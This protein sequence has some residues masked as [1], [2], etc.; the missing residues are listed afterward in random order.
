MKNAVFWDV[1][2][3][4]LVL[5]RH[6]LKQNTPLDNDSHAKRNGRHKLCWRIR[7]IS[8]YRSLSS[9]NNRPLCQTRSPSPA[10]LQTEVRIWGR[11]LLFPI[12]HLIHHVV[13][14]FPIHFT[15]S[16]N[17]LSRAEWKEERKI[18]KLILPQLLP[19][20]LKPRTE[21]FACW[22]SRGVMWTGFG[23][24]ELE[25]MKSLSNNSQSP[26]AICSLSSSSLASPR[27]GYHSY[28]EVR[29]WFSYTHRLS[30][31]YWGLLISLQRLSLRRS[32][33]GEWEWW[34]V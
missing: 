19:Q 18:R 33:L 31:L 16:K 24:A 12:I 10:P 9:H 22:M 26:V 28:Y 3:C 30:T 8:D 29:T 20:L 15:H 11:N 23:Y 32:T 17:F 25:L 6:E 27:T 5:V 21:A 1:T 4:S 2:P 34:R 13:L 7:K 14:R